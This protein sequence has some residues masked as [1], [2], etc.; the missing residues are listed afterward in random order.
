GE[1]VM[2]RTNAVRQII[3]G[4]EPGMFA[5]D[6]E[7][8]AK[9]LFLERARLAQHFV[10]RERHAQ[11]RIVAREAAVLAVVDALV[12]EIERREEA[13]DYAESLLSQGPRAPTE[14]FQQ[15]ARCR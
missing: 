15:L 6:Q 3:F 13:E 1:F 7:D 12:G 2:Q 8:V 4:N 9:A 14:R 5:G 10:H 11:N